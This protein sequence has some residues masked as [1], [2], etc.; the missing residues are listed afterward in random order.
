VSTVRHTSAVGPLLVSRS[1]AV[2]DS[3]R[4][5]L[6]MAGGVQRWPKDLFCKVVPSTAPELVE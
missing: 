4:Y 6:P 5:D 1:G 3:N 2:S